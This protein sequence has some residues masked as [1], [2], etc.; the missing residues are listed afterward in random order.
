LEPFSIHVTE[1]DVYGSR[2]IADLPSTVIRN[3]MKK[4]GWAAARWARGI[5]KM[6]KMT[7]RGEIILKIYRN[8]PD[9]SSISGFIETFPVE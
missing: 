9:R 7:E 1:E 3:Y 6:T 8:G 2:V 5:G 4:G